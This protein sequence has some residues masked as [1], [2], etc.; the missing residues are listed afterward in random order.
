MKKGGHNFSVYGLSLIDDNLLAS[1]SD[2]KT[3]KF[4]DLKQGKLKHT[5]SEHTGV[6]SILVSLNESLLASGSFD[7]TVKGKYIEIFTGI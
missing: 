3:V 6:V 2:D 7:K 4:W 1:C 5:F